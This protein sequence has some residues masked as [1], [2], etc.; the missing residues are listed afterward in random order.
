MDE[1]TIEE[2]ATEALSALLAVSNKLELD[3]M[4][5]IQVTRAIMSL[6]T[7]VGSKELGPTS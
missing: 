3:A 2:A 4:L 6:T 7:L 5:D 1:V